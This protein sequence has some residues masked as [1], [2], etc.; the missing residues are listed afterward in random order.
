VAAHP[1]DTELQVSRRICTV[2]GVS[3]GTASLDRD[4]ADLAAA[5]ACHSQ[6][7]TLAT[8]LLRLIR[9]GLLVDPTGIF[10]LS[11]VNNELFSIVSQPRDV[12]I[13]EESRADL[14]A[15]PE[16]PIIVPDN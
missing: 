16:P 4:R 8:L 15:L 9:T 11:S 7:R 2:A 6:L 5:V 14:L 1:G 13:P 12:I 10:S 3:V